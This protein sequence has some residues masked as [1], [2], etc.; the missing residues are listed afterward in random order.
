[1]LSVIVLSVVALWVCKF[2]AGS[3]IY[4]SNTV[5]SSLPRLGIKSWTFALFSFF[6][7]TLPLSHSGSPI[8]GI[9][10]AH[11]SLIVST[12]LWLILL[13]KI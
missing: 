13:R 2:Q 5:S 8:P 11:N 9:S 10:E 3:T 4:C 6:S 1:M 7:P 12:N